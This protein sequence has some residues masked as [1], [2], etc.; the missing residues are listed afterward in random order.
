MSIA[1]NFLIAHG[2]TGQTVETLSFPAGTD[3]V[4]RV[5]GIPLKSYVSVS[6]TYY[7]KR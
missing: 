7:F 5:M 2:Y 6:W 3:P 4:D 1:A